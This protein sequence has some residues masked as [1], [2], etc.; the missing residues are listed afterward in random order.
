MF[1]LRVLSPTF[2]LFFF[3]SRYAKPT[4]PNALYEAVRFDG[5]YDSP[6][7]SQPAN[8]KKCYMAEQPANYVDDPSLQ[9]PLEGAW[10]SREQR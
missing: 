9:S 5:R 6:V 4:Q 1:K 8:N 2:Q 7:L 10:Q 3:Q